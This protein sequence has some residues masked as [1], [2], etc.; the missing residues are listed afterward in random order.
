VMLMFGKNMIG[1][2]KDEV[3][4][5]K[6]TYCDVSITCEVFDSVMFVSKMC[7]VSGIGQ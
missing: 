7:I 2:V 1:I 6:R 5:W 3:H 4:Y